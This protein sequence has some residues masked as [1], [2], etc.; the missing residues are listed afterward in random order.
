MVVVELGSGT[1][2]FTRL[3]APFFQRVI[4]VEPVLE[5]TTSLLGALPEGTT[6]VEVVEGNAANIPLDNASADAMVS[7][8]AFH[9]FANEDSLRDM[10][11]VLKPGASLALV[12]NFIDS[13]NAPWVIDLH[14]SFGRYG[15]GVPMHR[16]GMWRNVFGEE[17]GKT[18]FGEEAALAAAGELISE[19][20]APGAAVKL[21]PLSHSFDFALPHNRQQLWERIE[22][23]SYI[24]VLSQEK[25]DDLQKEVLA[26][27][28]KHQLG[29]EI[30]M[31]YCTEVFVIQKLAQY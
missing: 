31:P 26:A 5:M 20:P 21:S 24:S 17:V 15:E 16:T 12:W 27:M 18:A 9:W 10:V 2:K 4:C 8:Q 13:T 30:T 28:D 23:T 22:S 14:K 3:I 19:R 25:R 29:A 1:G 6:N 11:R 7:A